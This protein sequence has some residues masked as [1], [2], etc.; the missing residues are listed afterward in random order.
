[1]TSPVARAGERLRERRRRRAR[2]LLGWVL[3]TW[4]ARHRK[5]LG[6]SLVDTAAEMV[7]ERAEGGGGSAVYELAAEVAA[8]LSAGLRLHRA[9]LG[10]SLSAWTVDLGRDVRFACRSAAR[11]P[12]FTAVVVLT[13]GVGIGANGAVFSLVEGVLLRPP[14]YAEPERLVVVWNRLPDSRERIPVAGPDA[15]EIEGSVGSF[16]SV[17][18]VLKPVNGGV[19]TTDGGPAHHVRISAVTPDFF[20]T[21]GVAPRL[22]RS[23]VQ[24]DAEGTAGA[25]G[26]LVLIS[27]GL[28]RRVLDG[29][30]TRVGRPLRLNG[31]SVV[32]AGVLPP[33]FGL[34]LSPL[35]GFATDIDVWLPL[36]VP[37]TAL[38]RTDGR[39]LDQDSDNSGAVV[40][41]LA[42]AASMGRARAELGAL[43]ARLA[44]EVPLY[45]E[46]ELAFD[47]R[48]LHD[49]ATAHA[50]PVLVALM[51]GVAGVLLV[52]CLNIA[53]LTMVRSSARRAEFAVRAC[54]GAGRGR[55]VRQLLLEG[56]VLVAMGLLVA[57][58]MAWWGLALLSVHVPGSLA[59]PGALVLEPRTL[60]FMAALGGGA[61]VVFG[62][63]PALDARAG[64][65]P[66]RRIRPGRGRGRGALVAVE[67]ALSVVMVFGAALLVRTVDA[68]ATTD[69]GFRP[70]DA[71]AFHVSLR[72]PE[73]YR[74]P[75][76]R[77]AYA[78]NVQRSVEEL[79][80]VDHVGWVGVL[81]LSGERWTQPYGL[82]GEGESEWRRNR[83]DFRVASSG[84]FEA[85]GAPLLDG[86]SFAPEEDR[87]ERAR[88]VVVD[89]HLARRIAPEGS[90]VGAVITIPLD[91]ARVEARVVGV[92]GA[93][94]SDRL[95]DAGRGAVY[96]PYRQEASRDVAFV[97]RTVGDPAD[98]A[99]AVRDAVLA[100]DPG[101]PPYDVRTLVSYVD[102]AMA[103]RRFALF[104][105]V[106]FAALALACAAVGLYGVVAFDAGR[107]TG[108]LGVRMA[109]GAGR[110]DVLRSV[111]GSG[112][113]PGA[114]GLGAGLAVGVAVAGFFRDLAYQVDV[115]D[116][117]LWTSVLLV[118]GAVA[119]VATVVPAWRASRL[120]PLEALRTE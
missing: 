4:P 93:I 21:L 118:V 6:A 9:E 83:A 107:R 58:V 111:L 65:A 104:L 57:A 10:A 103:P 48:P 23:F 14:G 51:M 43:A 15:A 42:P 117:A 18:F 64:V 55:L 61:V 34:A 75:A 76:Q 22:G 102:E 37:L 45:A 27:H 50:R 24:D 46:A 90:A 91:G 29:D 53:T 13:L 30:P 7:A 31:R 109:V 72:V 96:V 85:V 70:A 17:G 19:E 112:L 63:L 62:I 79:P 99:P 97:V 1:M 56:A 59:P 3:W 12:A 20:T 110:R 52:A 119:A 114:I 8:L 40:A 115:H 67:V 108:E 66:G 38:H 100:V 71:L 68:L 2:R 88:V 69:P 54:L 36:S 26:S 80:G 16:S 101:I 82:P 60:L 49:D 113:R 94:R 87:E 35:A 92:V 5:R 105:L 81:P 78:A 74:G 11:S 73:R 98:L 77:A 86:R 39:L 106:G 116:P 44:D 41:R 84:Y 33:D 28:Y 89:E 25:G 47:V 95:D 32:V 120:S